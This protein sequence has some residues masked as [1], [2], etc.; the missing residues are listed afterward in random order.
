MWWPRSVAKTENIFRFE[1]ENRMSLADWL[2]IGQLIIIPI[3]I[4]KI[5]SDYLARPAWVLLR[6]LV[7][8]IRSSWA[9][10]RP[11]PPPTEPPPPLPDSALITILA[12][13][14]RP[15]G[16]VRFTATQI[17]ILIGGDQEATKIAVAAARKGVAEGA[18][19]ET[20]PDAETVVATVVKEG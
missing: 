17:A 4:Y 12:T 9:T 11:A 8:L 13:L 15:S 5:I 20:S 1:E 3:V 18:S 16:R 10:W 14:R 6:P 19:E 2:F 7:A